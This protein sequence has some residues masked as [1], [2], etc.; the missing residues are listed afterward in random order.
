M[1][2]LLN[3]FLKGD[4]FMSRRYV[5]NVTI[6]AD[7]NEHVELPDYLIALENDFNYEKVPVSY[8]T[9]GDGN[10]VKLPP[11]DTAGE[12]IY[13]GVVVGYIHKVYCSVVVGTL[14]DCPPS[15]FPEEIDNF[16]VPKK[17]V[18]TADVPAIDDY[19]YFK[20]KM[21]RTKV[22]QYQL[23]QLSEE[24]YNR[25]IIARDINH[26]RNAVIELEK[27][28][29]V[30]EQRI[31]DLEKRM[32]EVE[33]RLDELEDLVV[34]DGEN[35]GSGEGEVF[36]GLSSARPYGNTM[37][38]RTLLAGENINITTSGDEVEISA[39]VP[40]S[41]GG[42]EMDNCGNGEPFRADNFEV[43]DKYIKFSDYMGFRFCDTQNSKSIL[44]V[45]GVGDG[46]SDFKN[47]G[48]IFKGTRNLV[49]EI[50]TAQG[51]FS[52]IDICGQDGK[53]I[54]YENQESHIKPI[55]KGVDP[56][57]TPVKMV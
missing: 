50:K 25:I 54:T 35:I 24:L 44:F 18:N 52:G 20:A 28:A 57:D 39:E 8:W 53:I 56:Y 13:E 12:F 34:I 30:L 33:R 19:Q 27:F 1:P 15:V 9:D 55:I 7:I 22:E 40:E 48:R 29:K 32:D 43:C 42:I 46:E 41:D 47:A 21:N 51:K 14:D 3:I 36:S 26:I 23:R 37:E 4:S 11:T 49:I 31:E 2:Y 6:M 16:G 10:R 45:L 17:D 5:E 38:F